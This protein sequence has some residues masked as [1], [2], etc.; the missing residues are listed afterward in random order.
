[1]LCGPVGVVPWAWALLFCLIDIIVAPG[2]SIK[3]GSM[4]LHKEDS[5]WGKCGAPEGHC[6]NNDNSSGN[7]KENGTNG[8]VILS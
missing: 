3:C 4:Q 8:N 6:A 1:M 2:T 7:N 5:C